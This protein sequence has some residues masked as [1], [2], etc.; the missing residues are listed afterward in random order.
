MSNAHTVETVPG[1]LE[2]APWFFSVSVEPRDD[3]IEEGDRFGDVAPD[4][5]IEG[6]EPS[7]VTVDGIRTRYYDVGSGDPLVL[8]HGGNWGGHWSANDW[9][10][11]FEY[12]RD[13]FRVLAF[14][15]VGCG[16]TENPSDP[17]AFRFDADL[18]HA[19]GFL[20]AIG[21]E[22]VH[23][24]GYSRGAGLATR[25]A[26]ER[27]DAV[28]TLTLTNSVTLGPPVGDDGYRHRRLFD[29]EELGLERTDPAYVRRR[30]EQY[31][32]RTDY[33][34]DERVR[35]AAYMAS[36]EKARRTQHVMNE[37]GALEKWMDS[38]RKHMS[39]ARRRV[40]NGVVSV[41]VHY[42]YGR[43]DLTMPSEM[44]MG[45]MDLFSQGNAPIRL[46]VLDECGHM[47]F[48][49]YPETFARR[50]RDLVTYGDG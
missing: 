17:A 27:P 26:V 44:A 1:S 28:R 50:V 34:T 39:E 16:M 37:G 8:V 11:T 42:L 46:T 7:F 48:L 12:L 3:M 31:S 5:G 40:R 29:M 47:V 18:E 45:A 10:A 30:L 24:A 32:Y 19:L 9:T 38:L 22:T 2:A 43:N 36:R 13:R 14:D 21:L 35:A 25:M 6:Y 4:A 41:P 49:E 15:R 23:L 33:V 20:D